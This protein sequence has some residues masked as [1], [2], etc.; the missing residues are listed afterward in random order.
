LAQR[1]QVPYLLTYQHQE[2]TFVVGPEKIE[3]KESVEKK[4]NRLQLND[5]V[6]V[7]DLWSWYGGLR[8]SD[9]VVIRFS[10]NGYVE[11]TV[12]HLRKDD[13]QEM[14]VVLSPF[15]GKVQIVDGYVLP[16]KETLFQ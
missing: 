5:T 7:L 9:A 6:T 2:R 16:E 12:I 13:G 4:E 11:P 1:H 8:S 15:V 3:K 14:S 10:K